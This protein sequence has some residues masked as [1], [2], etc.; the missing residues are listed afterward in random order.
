[1]VDG[2]NGNPGAHALTPGMVKFKTDSGDVITLCQEV[3]EI[4]VTVHQ[5][6][7]VSA[8]LQRLD[9]TMVSF[10]IAKELI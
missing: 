9:L 8:T 7:S 1:M 5:C 2:E 10:S 3:M 4:L 6:R